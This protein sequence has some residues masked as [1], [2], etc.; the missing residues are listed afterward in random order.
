[1]S[2]SGLGR[3][4]RIRG[5]GRFIAPANRAPRAIVDFFAPWLPANKAGKASQFDKLD[6]IQVLY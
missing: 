3:S 2:R 5:G 1:M 6:G 4:F